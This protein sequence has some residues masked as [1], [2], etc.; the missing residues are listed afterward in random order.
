MD[1]HGNQCVHLIIL[2]RKYY[3]KSILYRILDSI[4]EV[5]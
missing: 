4:L 2:S 1:E 3:V 5:N